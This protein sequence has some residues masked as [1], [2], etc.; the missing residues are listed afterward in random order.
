M[1]RALE[2]ADVVVGSR[3]V[4][5]GGTADWSRWRRFVSSLGNVYARLVL[6]LPFHDL[7]SGFVAYRAETLKL[8]AL[9]RVH[10][11]GYNFQIEM[12]ARAYWAGKAIEELPIIFHERRNQVSKFSLAIVVESFWQIVLLALRR[13]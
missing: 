7:T 5:N 9:Q 12:K 13:R 6:R 1:I 11:V 8:L 2:R 3:Y 4:K 10:S